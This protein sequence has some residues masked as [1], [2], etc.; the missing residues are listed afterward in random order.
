MST[1]AT[2]AERSTPAAVAADG[3]A[4][5]DVTVTVSADGDVSCAPDPLVVSVAR[6]TIVFRMATA[7]W[8]FAPQNAIVVSQPGSDFPQPSKTLPGGR[9]ATL[10]DLDLTAGAYAYTINVYEPSTGRKGSV[11]PTIE[12]QP[13]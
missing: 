1:D 2:L 10:L 3:Q 7:G 5:A 8:N 4:L 11:D 13:D 12:N 6:K 9:L